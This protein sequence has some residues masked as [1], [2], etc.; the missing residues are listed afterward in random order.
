MYAVQLN[1][2]KLEISLLIS[3][4]FIEILESNEDKFVDNLPIE[5]EPFKFKYEDENTQKEWKKTYDID[6]TRRSVTIPGREPYV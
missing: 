3:K 1:N 5:V 4:K 6:E 2:A